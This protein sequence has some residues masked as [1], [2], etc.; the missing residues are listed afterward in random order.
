MSIVRG[1]S[2]ATSS[3]SPSAATGVPSSAWPT[4]RSAVQPIKPTVAG[5]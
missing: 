1:A 3:A 2:I 4:S 5:Y